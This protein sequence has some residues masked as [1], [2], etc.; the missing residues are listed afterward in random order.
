MTSTNSTSTPT[1]PPDQRTPRSD[2]DPSCAFTQINAMALSS[3]DPAYLASLLSFLFARLSLLEAKATYNPPSSISIANSRVDFHMGKSS[4]KT[5]SK[6]RSLI[7]VNGR[8]F[9]SQN[10]DIPVADRHLTPMELTCQSC[11]SAF[12]YTPED[13]QRHLQRGFANQPKACAA[14]RKAR[15]EAKAKKPTSSS[16]E[17]PAPDLDSQSAHKS[18]AEQQAKWP[19]S[20]T[21]KQEPHRCRRRHR[22]RAVRRQQRA[23]AAAAKAAHS[24][25]AAP[26]AAPLAERPTQQPASRGYNGKPFPPP[27]PKFRFSDDGYLLPMHMQPESVSI[28]AW[29]DA[30][31]A[32]PRKPLY[33][34][35]H[36][37]PLDH[38]RGPRDHLGRLLAVYR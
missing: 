13:Q 1:T 20:L 19:A 10:T 30:K 11:S 29:R 16:T 35:V 3:Q 9:S 18:T 33:R 5:S 25:T 32:E 26:L 28:N 4:S 36:R 14:C 37:G 17:K 2:F 23:R 31:A 12:T 34:P 21:S 15:R 27:S 7:Y 6:G 24:T 38:L 8:V 22:P